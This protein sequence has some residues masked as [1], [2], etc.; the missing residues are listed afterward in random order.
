MNKQRILIL[1]GLPG[2][3]TGWNGV[4]YAVNFELHAM[5]E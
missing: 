5:D 2:S 3:G 4:Q 1:I